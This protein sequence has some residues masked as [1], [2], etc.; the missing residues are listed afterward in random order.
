MNDSDVV[1]LEE[2]DMVDLLDYLQVIARRRRMICWVTGLAFVLSIVISLLLPKIYSSTARIIPPQ[3]DQGLMAAMMGQMG[4]LAGLAGGMLGSGTTGD[5]YV[6]M[7]KSE[8]V[9]DVIIDKFKLMD[10]YEE[11]YR[12]DTYE[13][14]DDAATI[15]IGRKDGIISITV[16]DEDPARAAEMA[17]AFVGELEKLSVALNITG[18]GQN[19]KFLEQRLVK[20]KLDLARAED[21]LK[22]YQAKNKALDITEQAKVTIGGVAQLRAQLAVQE[23]QLA[24]LRSYLT[25]ENDEIKT[26]KASIANL[27]AQIASLESTSKGSSIPSVGS[28]PALGQEYLRLMREL[29]IQETIIEFITKQYEMAKF[30]EAKD[31]SGVQILQKATVPDKKTKPKRTLLVLGITFATF[32]FA[33]FLAFVLENVKWM[34]PGD[35]ERWRALLR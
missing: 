13:A 12:L 30:T 35:R 22:A 18:A 25:D 19:R 8:A 6:G 23:V 24:S 32:M 14:L 5:L 33:V 26:V 9:K 28:V 20:A 29:K 21:N 4:G 7:L 15:E 1:E 17:N 27:K 10:V 3:Q 2:K 16:E 11:D 34:S 31:V